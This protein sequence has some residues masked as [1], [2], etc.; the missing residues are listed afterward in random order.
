VF[1]VVLARGRVSEV[2]THDEL[3]RRQGTYAELYELQA[4]GYR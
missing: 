2:G 3:M 1:V 4:R